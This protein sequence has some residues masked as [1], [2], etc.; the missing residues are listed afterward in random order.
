MRKE[1]IS[2]TGGVEIGICCWGDSFRKERELC[3][4]KSPYLENPRSVHSETVKKHWDLYKSQVHIY[5]QLCY[6]TVDLDLFDGQSLQA[7]EGSQV[8]IQSEP[9]STFEFVHSLCA[10]STWRNLTCT[11]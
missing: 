7:F 11:C 5:E 10:K 6:T 2:L 3:P 1:M 9:H 8:L 4:R